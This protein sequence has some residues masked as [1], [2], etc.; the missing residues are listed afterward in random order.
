LKNAVEDS[1]VFVFNS[2]FQGYSN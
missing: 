1:N 2:L